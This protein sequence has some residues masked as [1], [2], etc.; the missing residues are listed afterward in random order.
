MITQFKHIDSTHILMCL[1]VEK[2]SHKLFY[3]TPTYDKT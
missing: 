3:E 1:I 2:R